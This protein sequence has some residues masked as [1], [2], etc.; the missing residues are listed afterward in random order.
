MLRLQAGQN[1]HDEDMIALVGEVST[2]S[3][4]F[5]KQWASQDVRL[6]RSD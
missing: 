3:E 1:P 4:A 5:R 2:R 6:H